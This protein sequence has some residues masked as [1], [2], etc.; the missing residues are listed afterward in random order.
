V[1]V[2]F[3]EERHI[4]SLWEVAQDLLGVLDQ[5]EPYSLHFCSH[6]SRAIFDSFQYGLNVYQDYRHFLNHLY[7]SNFLE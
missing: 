5:F 7:Q 3:E 4:A 2:S 6:L 1:E